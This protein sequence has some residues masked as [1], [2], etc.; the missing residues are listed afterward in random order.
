MVRN[1]G[2]CC[3]NTILQKQG[4]SPNKTIGRE[5]LDK[6]GLDLISEKVNLNLLNTYKILQWNVA[7]GIFLYRISSEVFPWM[8]QYDIGELPDFDNNIHPLLKNIGNFIKK[9][10]IRVSFHPG[11][12][13]VLGSDNPLVVEKTIKELNQHAEIF[14]LMG[15]DISYNY[16]I[17]IHVGTTRGGKY[18]SLR[19]FG[20]GFDLL[21]DNTKSCLVV[22]NDD[23]ENGYSV[24]DL[25][26]L[27]I[28]ITFDFFHYDCGAKGSLIKEEAFVKAYESWPSHI[29]PITHFSSSR[30]NYE[31]ITVKRNAHADYLY[32]K[33]PN[34][35]NY[36][37]D[38]EVEAK[39]K[40]Q[41][42]LK[43][44]LKYSL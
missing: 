3:I 5:N 33:I 17:N 2:Y 22:E 28:P 39:M 14:D 30:K 41:A 38:V 12:F 42:V 27:E 21:N 16:P 36:L 29:I 24:C 15:L 19:R 9:H 10:K 11:P 35:R 1:L 20:K 13:N 44:K 25:A 40:E 7:N 18:D 6:F 26:Q 8:S 32:E 23:S 43:Y 4:I 34:M 31:D 37:F